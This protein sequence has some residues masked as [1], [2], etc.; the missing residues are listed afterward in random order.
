V[1]RAA[2]GGPHALEAAD[3]LARL[4]DAQGRAVL[5]AELAA[6]EPARRR[7]A[8]AYLA[9]LPGARGLLERA[10]A[11]VD[12]EVRLSAAASVLRRFYR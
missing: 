11:D 6:S 10:L 1:L 12:A 7:V 5:D 4:G 8:L 3:E 2:L 9:P